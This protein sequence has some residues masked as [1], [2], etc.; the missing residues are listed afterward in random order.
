MEYKVLSRF[1][2][3]LMGAAMLWVMLFHSFD[4]DLGHPLLNRVRAAGFGGTAGTEELDKEIKMHY[5]IIEIR[6][7]YNNT[8]RKDE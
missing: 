6:Q 2:P 4:L 1:R 3:E 7:Q 8:K 5:C